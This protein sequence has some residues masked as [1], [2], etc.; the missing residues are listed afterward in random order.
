MLESLYRAVVQAIL[1]YGSEKW[2]LLESTEKRIEGEH[3]EFLQMITW[4]RAKQLEDGTWETPGAEGIQEAAGTQSARIY[5][6]K[7]Q[8]TLSQ[9]V[10]LRPLFEVCARETGYEGWGRSRKVW[11]RQEAKEKHLRATFWK[12]CRNLK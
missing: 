11:W 4:K 1:L 12:T 9:W 5:I 2:V 7:R 8:A 3:T 6:E 10:V